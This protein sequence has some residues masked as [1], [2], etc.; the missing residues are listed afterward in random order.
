[1]LVPLT[2]AIWRAWQ[3]AAG[4]IVAVLIVLFI[5]AAVV[6]PGVAAGGLL[7]PARHR[8]AR[9][10]P[11]ACVEETIGGDRVSLASWRC[12][13]TGPPRGTVIYL[14]GVADNRGSAAGWIERLVALGFDVVAYDSRAHGDSGGDACTYGY[15]EKRDLSAVVGTVQAEPIILFGTSLGAAVALQEAAIDPRVAAVIAAEPFSDLR[16]VATERAPAVL[17]RWLVRRAFVVAE[18]EATFEVNAVS[19]VEAARAVTI[20]VLL[21]HGAAD[22]DTRPDHSQRVFDALAGPKTFLLVPGA[23]HNESVTAASRDIER[24]LL[25]RLP[26]IH[27]HDDEATVGTG[28]PRRRRDA[29]RGTRNC[30]RP[31][32]GRRVRVLHRTKRARPTV[33]VRPPRND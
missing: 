2:V 13:A 8:V 1:M 14:H 21:L 31:R 11:T 3:P 32:R 7:H 25:E 12:R 4:V 10:T 16:T 26:Y 30:A 20:P 22:V 29:R 5:A 23:R 15:F 27:G 6:A 9:A 17:P 24:W 33:A 19:P 18:R 28:R